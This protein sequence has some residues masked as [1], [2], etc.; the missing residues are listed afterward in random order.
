MPSPFSCPSLQQM[1]S[2]SI[3][4]TVT[5]VVGIVV[6]VA[7]LFYGGALVLMQSFSSPSTGPAPAGASNVYAIVFITLLVG[8][9]ITVLGVQLMEY[10]R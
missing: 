1:A 9:I 2:A 10:S 6:L 7:G 3:P 4:G 5:V 8:L